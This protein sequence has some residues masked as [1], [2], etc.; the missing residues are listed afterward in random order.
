MTCVSKFSAYF[1]KH[2]ERKSYPFGWCSFLSW[3]PANFNPSS[4]FRLR[5]HRVAED[6]H[7][8]ADIEAER[9]WYT[10]W[11]KLLTI[12]RQWFWLQLD[13]IESCQH[14][15]KRQNSHCMLIV[16]EKWKSKQPSNRM[17]MHAVR[18]LTTTE[19]SFLWTWFSIFHG[20]QHGCY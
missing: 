6:D 20:K 12:H 18:E 16:G 13:H 15:F 1:S 10:P 19:N 5:F 4:D 17:W 8:L 2:N 11:L 14:P 3:G 7:E 9:M